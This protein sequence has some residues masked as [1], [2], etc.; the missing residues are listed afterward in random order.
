M[1]GDKG[2]ALIELMIVAAIIGILASD[3]RVSGLHRAREG[4]RDDER[5]RMDNSGRD[6]SRH[7]L[8]EKALADAADPEDVAPASTGRCGAGSGPA[9]AACNPVI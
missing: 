5:G 3:P 7:F 2:F 6:E 1:R 8:R 9:H 4:D